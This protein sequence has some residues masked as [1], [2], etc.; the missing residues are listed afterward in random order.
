MPIILESWKD[1]AGDDYP[2]FLDMALDWCGFFSLV[3]RDTSN[4]EESAIR[5]RRDLER[6]EV[7]RRRASHWPGTC[8]CRTANTPQADIITFRLD[9]TSRDILARPGS[10]F[11]WLAPAYPEDL[12]FYRREGR[13][14]LATVSH[15]RMAWAVDLDFG[16]S[17]PRHL[18]FTEREAE[19]AGDGGF[20]YVA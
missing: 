18:E 11:G 20:D 5:M 2:A 4:F 7:R 14:A 1:I 17:L 8:I 3:W 12:A 9:A 10:L 13:L 19:L 16:C 6:H 15:E